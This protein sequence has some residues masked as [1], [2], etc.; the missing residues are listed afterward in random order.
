M[1]RWLETAAALAAALIV[2]AL[3]AG[4][5]LPAAGSPAVGVAGDSHAWMAIPD[6]GPMGAA[7]IVHVPPRRSATGQGA[8]HDGTIRRATVLSQ[9]PERLAAWDNLLYLAFPPQELGA[10]RRHR[11]VVML[12]AERGPIQGS[13]V[14][15]VEGRLPTQPSLPGDGALVG[16]VGSPLGPVALLRAGARETPEYSLLVLFRSAWRSVPL[17]PRLGEERGGTRAYLAA[18]PE[19]PAVIAVGTRSWAAIGRLSAD[20]DAGDPRVSAEWRQVPLTFTPEDGAEPRLPY[21]QI[22]HVRGQ[23]VYVARTPNG[24]AVEI[25]NPTAT[26]NHRLQRIDD[27]GPDLAVVP[28]EQV[29]RLAILWQ[30]MAEEPVGGRGQ[31]SPA[32]TR[33]RMVEVSVASGEVLYEGPAKADPPISPGELKVLAVA[34]VGLMAVVLVFVLRP[35]PSGPPLSLPKGVTLAEPSRRMLAGFV[36]ATISI[37]GVSQAMGRSPFDLLSPSAF[38]RDPVTVESLLLVIAV[39]FIHTTL[40]EWLA[41]RSIGKALA[42]CEVVHVRFVQEED[43]EVRPVLERPAL[44]RAAVRNLLRWAI[45]PLAISGLSAPDHRHRGDLAAGTVVVV[46][47]GEDE[48]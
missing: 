15:P 16:F 22:Y 36:D 21:S 6:S 27:V 35:D 3:A 32:E 4:A 18:T 38:M 46:R 33:A 10:G 19:G 1:H 42:G 12:S 44:W 48:A 26:V 31:S 39:G 13:W 40:G 11:R 24:R 47:P 30:D 17:P 9:M 45:P 2:T 23:F 28:V 5:D 25:W 37:L 41:G 7:I 43:G 8:A 20:L 34:L 29:G 14:T